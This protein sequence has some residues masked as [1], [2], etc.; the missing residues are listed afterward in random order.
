IPC[1]NKTPRPNNL[2]KHKNRQW[3]AWEKL[4]M[5]AYLEKIPGATVRRTADLFKVQPM[6]IREWRNKQGELMMAQPHVK[7]LN[8]GAKPSY[9]DLE[10][11]L[12]DWVQ[13][14]RNELKSVSRSMVQIKAVALAKSQQYTLQYP[15]IVLTDGSEENLIFDYDQVEG[16]KADG[17]IFSNSE[18]TSIQQSLSLHQHLHHQDFSHQQGFLPQQ[19]FLLQGFSPQQ[20][21]VQQDLSSQQHFSLQEGPSQQRPLSQQ[22]LLYHQYSLPQQ[23]PAAQQP[24]QNITAQ[25]YPLSQQNIAAQQYPL[26]QQN[27]TAQQCFSFQPYLSDQSNSLDVQGVEFERYYTQNEVESYANQWV[28]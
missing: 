21:F 12:A 22:H 9:P 1:L 20:H 4:F 14:L 13:S 15:N 2:N 11:E 25:Q 3:T 19:H 28:K 23:N 27:L 17:F 8:S 26:L 24:Q 18:T 5:I 16:Y 7:R 6:Q 10:V